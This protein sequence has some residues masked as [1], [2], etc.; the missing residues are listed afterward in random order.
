[1]SALIRRLLESFSIPGELEQDI[2]SGEV[3]ADAGAGDVASD[4]SS[5]ESQYDFE[6]CYR[7]SSSDVLWYHC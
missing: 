1:V 4:T 7:D 6:T 2:I 3:K 5:D